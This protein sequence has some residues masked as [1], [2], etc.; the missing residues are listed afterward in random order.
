MIEDDN[1]PVSPPPITITCF[2]FALIGG[3]ME[4]GEFKWFSSPAS[5]SVFVFP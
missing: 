4:F 5:S 2:P 3:V 1:L